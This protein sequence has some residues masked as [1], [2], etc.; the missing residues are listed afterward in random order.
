MT[1]EETAPGSPGSEDE[2]PTG[3]FAGTH[4]PSRLETLSGASFSSGDARTTIGRYRLLQRV[5]EGGMGEVWE[6]EQL[7]PV[8]R[9]VAVKVI[10]EG[11]DTRTVVA[12]FEAERKALALMSHPGVARVFDAGVTPEGRPFFAMEF[13]KGELI[14]FYCDRHRLTTRDVDT[15]TDV[16]SLGVVLYELLTGALPFDSKALRQASLAEIQRRIREDEPPRPSTRV[17]SLGDDSSAVAARHQTEASVLV[18]R[19]RGDLDAITMKA[20]EKDRTRRYDSPADLAADL[21]RHLGNEPV[22]ASPPSTAYR[23]RK[24]VKRHKAVVATGAVVALA[25]VAGI[26]GTTAGML[27]ARA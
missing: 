1:I 14:N 19:L 13:V 23:L 21:R 2:T 5:G 8:K 11:M 25:L 24:F 18:R 7:S 9:R 10:K 26:A 3:T 16:Y 6:A 27:R 12:R 22:L 17:S 15:R 4:F 20:L